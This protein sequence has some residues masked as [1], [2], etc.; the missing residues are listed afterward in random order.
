MKRPRCI[1]L[2]LPRL[3]EADK[4]E[5]LDEP[6]LDDDGT[7]KKKRWVKAESAEETKEK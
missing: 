2:T 4:D 7:K 1:W 6:E 3:A 5:Q